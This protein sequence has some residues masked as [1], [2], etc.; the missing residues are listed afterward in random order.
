MSTKKRLQHYLPWSNG[1]NLTIFA[2]LILIAVGAF[3]RLYRIEDF[4]TFLGD[5]G[6]DAIVMKRIATGEDFPGIGPRSSIGDLFLGPFY[7]YIMAP[8]LGLFN[9]NPVGPAIGVAVMS[10]TAI[11]A[12]FFI[13]KREWSAISA[14]IFLSFVTF[15]YALISYSRF[16]WNPNL[17]PF[18]SFFTIFFAYQMLKT[19]K[20]R[21]GFLFGI[22]LGASLQLHYLMLLTLPGVALV[23]G[24]YLFRNNDAWKAM[25]S[26]LGAAL[27]GFG[28]IYAPMILF[29]LKNNFLNL[30]GLLSI[31]GEKE[32]ASEEKNILQRFLESNDAIAQHIFQTELPIWVGT[33]LLIAFIFYLW[34]VFKKQKGDYFIGLLGASVLS[35]LLLFSIVDTQRYVHYFMPIYFMVFALIASTFTYFQNKYRALG[36]TIVVFIFFIFWNTQKYTFFTAEANQQTKRAESIASKINEASNKKPYY[37]LSIPLSNTN[38]HIRYYLEIMGNRPLSAESTDPAEELFVLCYEP[39]P[40]VCNVTEDPQ[41]QAVIFGDRKIEQKIEHPPEVTIYKL[42]HAK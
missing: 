25:V 38:D 17:L 7:F 29:E 2:F 36:I 41:Y 26:C 6:R 28:G 23:F 33:A 10:I 32:F 30:R 35:F 3:F 11:G 19:K 20:L 22:F 12:S 31:F 27:A 1:K 16:S 9:F 14:F 42:I 18:F 34:T 37:L 5:Q 21:Y 15:S 8:F 40:E 39:N 13:I 4:I 24:Y